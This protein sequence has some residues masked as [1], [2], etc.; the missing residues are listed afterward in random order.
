MQTNKKTRI[1]K[2]KKKLLFSINSFN[3][4]PFFKSLS[5]KYNLDI[6]NFSI[7]SQRHF[8]KRYYIDDDCSLI[9]YSGYPLV[10]VEHGENEN[11]IK[12]QIKD[13]LIDLGIIKIRIKFNL[14]RKYEQ[15]KSK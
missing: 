1:Y 6:N 14:K 12:R 10:V 7:L 13:S 4:L 15:N 8:L 11:S 3:L 5:K 9:Y 2:K